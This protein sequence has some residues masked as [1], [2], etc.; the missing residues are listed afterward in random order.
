MNDALEEILQV[1]LDC[2]ACRNNLLFFTSGG[3][4]PHDHDHERFN[5]F[6]QFPDLLFNSCSV[7]V[8]VLS[9][10][11]ALAEYSSTDLAHLDDFDSD[12]ERIFQ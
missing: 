3:Y 10:C 7:L 6:L 12:T 5:P 11:F 2:L 9:A 8:N 1:N 4:I